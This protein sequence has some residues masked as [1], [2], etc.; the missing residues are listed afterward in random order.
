[1]LITSPSKGK[2]TGLPFT[3][4]PTHDAIDVFDS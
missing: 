1:M 2:A 3:I 4:Q